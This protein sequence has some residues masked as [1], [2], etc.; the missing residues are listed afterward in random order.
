MPLKVLLLNFPATD[1]TKEP[2]NVILT[3][4]KLEDGPTLHDFHAIL[5]DTEEI[6][7]P[8]WWAPGVQ[9]VAFSRR[10]SSFDILNVKDKIR[11]QIVTGGLVFCFSGPKRGHEFRSTPNYDFALDSY[12]FCPIDLGVV[13]ER[14][15]TFSPKTE[16]LKYYTPLVQKIPKQDIDWLCHFSKTPENT[17]IIGANRAGYPVFIEVPFG[18]G[19]L[20]MLPHFKNR[21]QA[22]TM[23]VN[24]I[25]PRMIA[26]ETFAF[27]PQWLDIYVSTLEETLR[28]TLSEIEKSKR[29]LYTKDQALKK[30]V[31]FAFQKIGFT[32][33]ILPDGTLPD[34]RLK[35]GESSSIVEVKGHENKQSHRDDVLQIMGYM[36]ETDIKEKGLVVVNHQFREEPCKRD[37]TAFTAGAIDLAG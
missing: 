18:T 15:D 21:P 30:A 26:E 10:Y 25:I 5:V 11:E 32:V 34:L 20:V 8:Q 17:R 33:E 23:I 2:S 9:G 12:F 31:A 37:A 36:S 7:K 22:A 27:A 24:E 19:K 4:A 1:I 16:E 3:A 28:Q 14:G 35:D 13:N 6:L 29:L